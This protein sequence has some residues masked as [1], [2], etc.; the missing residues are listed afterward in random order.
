MGRFK[1]SH[2][3]WQ[4]QVT[5]LSLKTLSK[6]FLV[7][8]IDF[9]FH[10]SSHR[11]ANYQGV[12][13]CAPPPHPSHTLMRLVCWSEGHKR[14]FWE[15]PSSLLR[16]FPYTYD[17]HQEMNIEAYAFE[18]GRRYCLAYLG[19]CFCSSQHNVGEPHIS[20]QSHMSY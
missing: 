6:T 15:T 10:V 2:S 7:S 19:P 20:L 3:V 11:S 13:T 12:I 1:T 14:Y 4:H 8:G 16:H 18:C 9:S 17:L 5:L